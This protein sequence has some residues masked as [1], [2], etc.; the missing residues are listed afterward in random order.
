MKILFYTTVISLFFNFSCKT[1]S[2]IHIS[3]SKYIEDKDIFYS[4]EININSDSINRIVKY[5]ILPEYNMKVIK[6]ARC[7]EKGFNTDVIYVGDNAFTL[8][9]L[10]SNDKLWKKENHVFCFTPF[11]V[12]LFE[13]KNKKYILLYCLPYFPSSSISSHIFLF[14][15]ST[16]DSIVGYNLGYTK[17]DISVENLEYN[18][19]DGVLKLYIDKSTN[20]EKKIIE[21]K[22]QNKVLKIINII[23]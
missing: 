17:N 14:D 10:V 22:I 8:E 13:A 5:S 15:V 1:E 6:Y 7:Q 12:E 19:I 11:R 21:L 3:K 18:E 16:K 9:N 4:K 23:E 2:N 20:Y